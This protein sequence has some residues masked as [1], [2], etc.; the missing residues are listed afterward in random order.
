MMTV[1]LSLA[2]VED[3]VDAL[4]RCLTD[5]LNGF[6]ILDGCRACDTFE[7][8]VTSLIHSITESS[9]L[10]LDCWTR[11]PYWCVPAPFSVLDQLVI[12]AAR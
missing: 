4:R 9:G 11:I 5:A 8:F 6:Q 12:V 2:R 1:N 3:L 10:Q 7:E